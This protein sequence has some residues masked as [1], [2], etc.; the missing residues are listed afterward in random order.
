MVSWTAVVTALDRHDAFKSRVSAYL[1]P[2]AGRA[3]VWHVVR[4]LLDVSPPPSE[5]CVL[6][7]A[8]TPLR[9]PEDPRVP[10]R[11]LPVVAG[12]E[13]LALRAAVT[14]LGMSVLVDGA[15]PLLT[16]PTIARLLRVADHGI[17]TVCDEAEPR[18]HVAV[19]G[20]GPAL[21][22]A[23]DP[24]CP[25][26]AA[27]VSP[28]ATEELLRVVDR[29]SLGRASVAMRDRL[30]RAHEAAG[31]T[32]LLPSSVLV[33]V[34]V[35]IGADTVV[36]PGVVLEGITEIAGECVI[37]PYSRIVESTIGRGA[38]LKG[39]NYVSRTSVRNHAILE[40]HV[41]RGQD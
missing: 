4:A 35:R 26:G 14:S 39:W 38:E 36:Y 41:R 15:A 30:L 21:A 16:P 10:V 7:A 9:L 11:V 32:F 3:V 8:D 27:R 31:V 6:H 23:D 20:E 25:V 12:Q 40:P 34:D 28:T 2:L 33:D 1:H 19:A 22:S 13:L 17:A 18:Q 5:V 29:L 37:G 24:R